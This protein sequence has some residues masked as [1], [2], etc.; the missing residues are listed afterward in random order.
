[1]HG[2][3]CVIY[4]SVPPSVAFLPTTS[5]LPS[6]PVV[7][8]LPVI[9]KVCVVLSRPCLHHH[10]SRAEAVLVVLAVVV[11]V[12]FFIQ[13]WSLGSDCLPVPFCCLDLDCY[14]VALLSGARC[15]VIVPLFYCAV[16][17]WTWAAI[18][19]SRLCCLIITSCAV[20]LWLSLCVVVLGL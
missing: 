3:T 7:F 11:T 9:S 15:A 12:F 18:Y 6:A 17:I 19:G 10:I 4:K 5:P 8:S 14:Y 2:G 20:W 1:M 16:W 13:P